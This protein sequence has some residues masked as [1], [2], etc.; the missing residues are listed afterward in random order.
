MDTM[1]DSNDPISIFRHY[2]FDGE[3]S[4]ISY[5][6]DILLFNDM[7][8]FPKCQIQGYELCSS[9][10]SVCLNGTVIHLTPQEFDLIYLL[11]KAPR[12]I[13]S[14]EQLIAH[15][16]GDSYYGSKRIIDNLIWR[17]RRKLKLLTIDTVY[18]YGY[19]AN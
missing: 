4:P 9:S 11:A 12:K 3:I 6:T 13:F 10:R 19:R 7:C 15:I 2:I 18:G 8:F 1:I 5:E 17:I 16:W 14:R